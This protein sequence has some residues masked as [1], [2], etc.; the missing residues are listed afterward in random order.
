MTHFCK[1]EDELNALLAEHS[2]ST[3]TIAGIDAWDVRKLWTAAE[4]LPV[5][6][7]PVDKFN[8][9]VQKWINFETEVAPDGR[10]IAQFDVDHFRRIKEADLSYPI[11]LS[12]TGHIMDGMHRLIKCYL[13]GQPVQFVQF[14]ITPEPMLRYTR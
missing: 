14:T 4:S 1:S 7:A 5:Q 3:E 12:A 10:R 2:Y 11:I 13:T 9:A 6:V 8:V